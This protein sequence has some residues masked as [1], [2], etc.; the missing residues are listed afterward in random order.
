[1]E[2]LTFIVKMNSLDESWQVVPLGDIHYG[3]LGCDEEKF[4]SVVKRISEGKNF[5]TIGMGDYVENNGITGRNGSMNKHF[6]LDAIAKSGKKGL[7]SEQRRW[8][9]QIWQ[10]LIPKT[11]G[12]LIGNHEDRSMS[13]DEFKEMITEPLGVNYLGDSAYINLVFTYRGKFVNNY[14]ILAQHSRFDT[15]T[16]GTSINKASSALQSWDFD[17]HLFGHTHFALVDKLHRNYLDTIAET[18]RI[19]FRKAIIANTGAFLRANVEGVDS[20]TD[21]TIGNVNRDVGTITITFEPKTGEFYG[22]V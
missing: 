10:P 13:H 22:H 7:I 21:K 16:H 4:L 17:V 14:T 15:H 20:Y 5:L 8:I 12:M 2:A 19:A 11:I 3:A 9:K 18:P 6:D 1:L